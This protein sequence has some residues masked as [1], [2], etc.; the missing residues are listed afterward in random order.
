MININEILW[1]YNV[2]SIYIINANKHATLITVEKVG[3]CANLLQIWYQIQPIMP[4]K[5]HSL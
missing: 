2:V 4:V 1:L 5:E 3:N